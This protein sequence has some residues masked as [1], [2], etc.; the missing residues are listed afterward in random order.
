MSNLNQI[1]INEHDLADQLGRRNLTDY[2]EHVV[3]AGHVPG[4]LSGSEIK[5]KAASYGG[6]YARTRDKVASAVAKLVAVH[7]GYV[8]DADRARRVR[9]WVDADG[10]PVELTVV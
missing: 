8:Y 2:M 9:V 3:N 6:S 4:V 1:E 10:T 5:G 7:D